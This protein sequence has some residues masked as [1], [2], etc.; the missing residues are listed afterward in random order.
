MSATGADV[1]SGAASG[2]NGSGSTSGSGASST[3]S[4][5][6]CSAA[7]ERLL[8]LD[9]LEVAG[10]VRRTAQT[11]RPAVRSR[12]SAAGTSGTDS[13][14]G[15]GAERVLL[16]LTHGCESLDLVGSSARRK[17]E[18]A[19]VERNLGPRSPRSLHGRADLLRIGRA[20]ELWTRS[21]CARRRSRACRT[22]P[23]RSSSVVS[24]RSSESSELGERSRLES[25]DRRELDGSSRRN[26]LRLVRREASRC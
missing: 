6:T 16:D 2:S 8:E 3:G 24:P 1:K 9:R 21:S 18:L 14:S 26:H 4:L 15:F 13:D 12:G 20:F 19:L 7:K 23:R 17:L 5:S 25:V 22:G 10:V 11:R